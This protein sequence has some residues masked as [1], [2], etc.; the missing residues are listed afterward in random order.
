LLLFLRELNTFV[1]RIWGVYPIERT[2][3]PLANISYVRVMREYKAGEGVPLLCF[4]LR[5]T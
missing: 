5:V 1:S 2:T 4:S 3:V